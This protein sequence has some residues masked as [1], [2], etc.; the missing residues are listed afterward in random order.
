MGWLIAL[1]ILVLL[2]LL[3]LG[4]TARYDADGGV[5]TLLAGPVPFRLI[6]KKQKEKKPKQKKEKQKGKPA[7]AAAGQQKKEKKGGSWKDFVPLVQ[8]VLEFLNDFRRKM[9]IDRLDL[10]MIMAGDDPCDLAINYGRAN[11]ALGNLWPMLER[12]FV[13]KKRNVEIECDFQA[14]EIVVIAHAKATITLGRLL[15][16]VLRYGI[17]AIKQYLTIQKSRKGGASK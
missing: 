16:L 8:T 5:V 17:R 12:C 14:S 6:P 13:I 10:K 7:A 15:A 4:V 1:V 11:A 9:R 2:A 3:P